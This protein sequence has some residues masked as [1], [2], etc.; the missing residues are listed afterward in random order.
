MKIFNLILLL[1]FLTL[2]ACEK[3]KTHTDPPG[4]ENPELNLNIVTGIQMRDENGQP[5]G[6]AGN[7]NSKSGEISVFPNPLIDA[8]NVFILNGFLDEIWILKGT[9][10]M[11]FTTLDFTSILENHEVPIDSI[12]DNKIMEFGLPSDQDIRAITLNLQNLETGYYRIFYK[13]KAGEIFW[14]NLKVDKT[15]DPGERI[16]NLLDEWK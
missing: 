5:I 4:P 6:N 1:S 7:P 8:A 2:F 11:A 14:D 10:N 13:T 12:S 16:S 9:Q 15:S 3:E